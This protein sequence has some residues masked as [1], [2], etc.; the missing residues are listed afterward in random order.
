MVYMNNIRTSTVVIVILAV[1]SI[2][3]P[4]LWPY[5]WYVSRRDMLTSPTQEDWNLLNSVRCVAQGF[6]VV[7]LSIIGIIVVLSAISFFG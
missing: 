2:Y 3:M 1:I 5:T 4:L 6:L 7:V